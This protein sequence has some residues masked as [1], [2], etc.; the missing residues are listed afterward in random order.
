[1]SIAGA[2][3]RSGAILPILA[4]AGKTG[5]DNLCANLFAMFA[6]VCDNLCKTLSPTLPLQKRS[7]TNGPQARSATRPKV[8]NRWERSHQNRRSAGGFHNSFGC[9]PL[10]PKDGAG[11]F[12]A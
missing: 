11:R 12:R 2:G 1:V 4:H 9:I 7:I 3:H 6:Q 8:G 5:T 10:P